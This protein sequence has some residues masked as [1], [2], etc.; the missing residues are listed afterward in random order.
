MSVS[1]LIGTFISCIVSY[2]SNFANF[3]DKHLIK[4]SIWSYIMTFSLLILDDCKGANP[5]ED[6]RWSTFVK[7]VND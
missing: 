1:Y 6:L 4:I 7:I 3:E 2:P 5:D